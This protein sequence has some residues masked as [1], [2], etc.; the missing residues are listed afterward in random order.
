M[1]KEWYLMTRKK[2]FL[3]EFPDLKEAVLKLKEN[4]WT[5]RQIEARTGI[6]S[7]TIYRWGLGL[8]SDSV[9]LPPHKI[10]EMVDLYNFFMEELEKAKSKHAPQKKEHKY[11]PSSIRKRWCDLRGKKAFIKSFPKFKESILDLRKQGWAFSALEALTGLDKASIHRWEKDIKRYDAIPINESEEHVEAYK[12]FMSELKKALVERPPTQ[13][14]I[15]KM[16]L[17][18]YAWKRSMLPQ[19]KKEESEE[20]DWDYV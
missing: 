10:P 12:F 4:G 16:G 17:E 2:S 20:D 18:F 7:N 9:K 11:L 19:I 15:S 13:K 6:T 8:Q 1:R 5:F 3:E 14:E